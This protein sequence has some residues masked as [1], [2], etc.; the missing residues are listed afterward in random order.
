MGGELRLAFLMFALNHRSS[1][2]L[3][4]RTILCCVVFSVFLVPAEAGWFEKR[5]A[6]RNAKVV[7]TPPVKP[8]PRPQKR[9][10]Y[11]DSHSDAYVNRVLLDQGKDAERKVII[12]IKRQRVFLVIND[13]VAIDSAIS[14]AR[15]GKYTPRGTFQITERV[16]SGKTSTIYHVYM[17]YWMRLGET[18]VG[19]HIGDLP[20]Y[21]ASAGC[22][23]LPQSVAPLLFENTRRGT[24]VE[25][26]DTWNEE[27]LKI[28]YT[29][30]KP[31]LFADT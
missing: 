18:A 28:P 14:T 23:R 17:P 10:S 13:L 1:F 19:M 5:K 7:L 24:L 27:G 16:V 25:V 12:D 6:K 3:V 29:I 8:T 20:G 21:P 22:I 31:A 15:R 9:S 11:R 4:S 30:T 2:R 26:V